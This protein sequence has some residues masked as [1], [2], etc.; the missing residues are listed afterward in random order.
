[1]RKALVTA[2]ALISFGFALPALA[3]A[4]ATDQEPGQAGTS[5]SQRDHDEGDE[6]EMMGGRML[7]RMMRG[8]HMERMMTRLA[9]ELAQGVFYRVKRGDDEVILHCPQNMA[10]N[11]CVSGATELLKGMSQAAEQS[12]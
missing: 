4:P 9:H 6:H 2:T 12:R 7:G 5:A 10:L 11:A 1:M 3:Q 8:L